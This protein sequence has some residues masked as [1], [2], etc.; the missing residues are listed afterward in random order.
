MIGLF[1]SWFAFNQE[2]LKLL[3]RQSEQRTENYLKIDSVMLWSSR[4]V[5][6]KFSTIQIFDLLTCLGYIAISVVWSS[7]WICDQASIT[8]R[9]ALLTESATREKHNRP[10]GFPM[11]GRKLFDSGNYLQFVFGA[12]VR[13]C[14]T[15]FRQPWLEWEWSLQVKNFW[16][17]TRNSSRMRLVVV[18][19]VWSW[20]HI[21]SCA[22]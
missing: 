19:P 18:I 14:C 6:S 16:I 2:C 21:D 20:C 15:H 9:L 12:R 22:Q 11:T 3:T 4:V 8:S 1:F 5:S 13:P 7:T 17:L 10:T